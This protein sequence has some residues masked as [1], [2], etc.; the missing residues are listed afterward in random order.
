M[1]FQK[2]NDCRLWKINKLASRYGEEFI[3]DKEYYFD[4]KI[5]F[6]PKNSNNI[7]DNLCSIFS[8]LSYTSPRAIVTDLDDTF[9]KGILGDDGIDKIDFSIGSS[10][11]EPYYIYQNLL[12][13]LLNKGILINISSKNDYDYVKKTF[14]KRKFKIKFKDFTCKKI[15]W[16]KKSENIFQISKE[17]NLSLGNILFID[18][19]NSERFEV[20]RHLKKIKVIN[21]RSAND[22]VTNINDSNFFDTNL[23][24][25]IDR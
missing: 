17:L 10:L 8:Q 25:K 12:K 14:Q 24:N 2:K 19:N 5:F 6:N 16:K 23:N 1:K 7:S 22:L 11:T 18:D 21:F 4:N 3:H 13:K 9:W 15:N 20:L